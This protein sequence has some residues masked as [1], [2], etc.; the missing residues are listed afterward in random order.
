[1]LTGIWKYCLSRGW[2]RLVIKFD[3]RRYVEKLKSAGIPEA[4]AKASAEALP[5]ALE[6]SI[7]SA[8]ATKGNNR[9]LKASINEFRVAMNAGFSTIQISLDL[10]RYGSRLCK[11]GTYTARCLYSKA[12]FT[13]RMVL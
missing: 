11:H 12:R 3:T 10:L 2:Y 9:D 4:H 7:S 1:M 8:L 5:T 13:T 6:Q